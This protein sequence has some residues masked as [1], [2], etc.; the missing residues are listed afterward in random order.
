MQYLYIDESGSM[1]TQ[2]SE[3]FPAFIICVIRVFNKELLKKRITRFIAK[4]ITKLRDVDKNNKMFKNNHFVELKGSALSYKL[5]IDLANCLLQSKDLFE[6]NILHISNKNVKPNTYNNTARAFNYFID[7]FM[8]NRFKKNIFPHD[9]YEIC[10]DERNI[11]TDAKRTLE[12]YLAT[13]FCLK[14]DYAIN[15][16]V[17]YQD[18]CDNKLIQLS[19]FFANLY[20]SYLNHKNSYSTIINDLKANNLLKYVFKFPPEKK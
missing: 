13:E 16:S 17:S 18:S 3:S 19:D 15:I 8:T 4:N 6:I 20:F 1:T 5:K 2:F 14:N 11:R 10:I 7:L 12:D 9:S